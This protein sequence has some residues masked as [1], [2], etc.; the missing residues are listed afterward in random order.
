MTSES[1]L[2]RTL[3]QQLRTF[4]PQFL[5]ILSMSGIKLHGTS[6][7]KAATL[8]TSRSEGF[9]RGLPDISLAINNG[10]TLHLELKRPD[11]KGVQSQFQKDIES[12][13]TALGHH[14]YLIKDTAIV[15]NLIAKHTTAEYRTQCMNSLPVDL[16]QPTLTEDFLFFTK[17]TKTQ[18]VKDTLLEQYQ[19][20]T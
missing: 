4:Y 15:F 2:Q 16:T 1:T 10:K 20:D 18:L 12:Q 19:L 8:A 5:V 6:A 14:Y 9:V 11:G 3:V 7:Q 17:G 13:L